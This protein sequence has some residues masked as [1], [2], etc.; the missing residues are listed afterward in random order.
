M[1]SADL[2]N[3][4][5]DGRDTRQSEEQV[6]D[7]AVMLANEGQSIQV[8][9][10]DSSTEQQAVPAVSNDSQG[11][12][13][14]GE[15]FTPALDNGGTS[16]DVEMD[17]AT[18]DTKGDAPPMNATVEQTA[19][20]EAG[21]AST[22][23][24]TK[25]D[26]SPVNATVGQTTELE[27]GS[28]TTIGDTKS[29]APLVDATVEETTKL[30]AGSS[31]T[32]GDAPPVYVT[33]E[34]TVK[35]EAGSSEQIGG[36]VPSSEL[37][38]EVVEL[39]SG[40]RAV[41]ALGAE[42]GS[43][44]ENP[45]D[46]ARNLE[47]SITP[48]GPESSLHG[49]SMTQEAAPI[50]TSS[51]ETSSA[52]DDQSQSFPV[53][54]GNSTSQETTPITASSGEANPAKGL[55][56]E[57]SHVH[58]GGQEAK[59]ITTTIS[60]EVNPS[61]EVKST[62]DVAEKTNSDSAMEVDEFSAPIVA[63]VDRRSPNLLG[64]LTRNESIII[65]Q[66]KDANE[67]KYSKAHVLHF[68][69]QYLDKYTPCSDT[70]KALREDVVRHKLLPQVVSWDGQTRAGNLDDVVWR[71]GKINRAQDVV[72]R[73]VHAVHED[74]QKMSSIS[75][76][77][78]MKLANKIIGVRTKIHDAERQL[79]RLEG[80]RMVPNARFEGIRIRAELETL[81]TEADTIRERLACLPPRAKDSI[82]EDA[83][84]INTVSILQKM[85]FVK[86]TQGHFG[87]V[88]CICVDP[89]GKFIV[90]GADDSLIKVW[91]AH[92][93]DLMT[94]LRGHSHN[95]CDLTMKYA[96]DGK[97][98]IL[99]STSDDLTIR[100]WQLP[101]GRALCVLKGHKKGVE[102][103]RFDKNT[104]VLFSASN[105]GSL[106]MWDTDTIFDATVIRKVAT[107]ELDRRP[108]VLPHVQVHKDGAK[109]VDVNTVA[110][111]PEGEVV[112]S[113]GGDGVIR[114]WCGQK[115]PS[116]EVLASCKHALIASAP[117]VDGRYYDGAGRLIQLLDKTGLSVVNTLVWSVTGHRLLATSM[118]DGSVK[119]WEWKQSRE[120]LAICASFV[121]NT[122]SFC[123]SLST[124][125][126]LPRKAKP[127]VPGQGQT[128]SGSSTSKTKK[129]K[130]T[131]G[132]DA[133]AWSC[134][135]RWIITAQTIVPSQS[136]IR[137]VHAYWDQQL[138]VWDTWANGELVHVLRKHRNQCLAVV[139][140]PTNPRLCMSAGWDGLVLLWD[141]IDGVLLCEN[142]SL[143]SNGI[144]F[145]L[146]LQFLPYAKT[147]ADL[148]CSDSMGRLN[149]LS[150]GAGK[151][152]RAAPPQQFF[153]ND[154]GQL[155]YDQNGNA[156]D[157]AS[158]LPPH[159]VP[160]TKLCD[161]QLVPYEFQLETHS[162][163]DR[164]RFVANLENVLR[165]K[166]SAALQEVKHILEAQDKEIEDRASGAVIQAARE[167]RAPTV[168]RD[169]L[170]AQATRPTAPATQARRTATNA[171]GTTTNTAP[172][173]VLRTY[174][175]LSSALDDEAD[176]NYDVNMDV[177]EKD[178]D[179]NI[180]FMPLDAAD[181]L[182]PVPG[183]NLAVADQ[184]VLSGQE[185]SSGRSVRRA[186]KR[187]Q[188]RM[189]HATDILMAP[190]SNLTTQAY[191]EEANDEGEVAVASPK[192][193]P[194]IPGLVTLLE[195]EWNALS[196]KFERKWVEQH[197]VRIPQFG[198]SFIYV[199]Q[200][201]QYHNQIEIKSRTSL[202]QGQAS[203]LASLYAPWKL[204][205]FSK[206]WSVLMC[207]VVD[208]KYVFPF[209]K[210]SLRSGEQV[211]V[212]PYHRQSNAIVLEI[213]VSVVMTPP[214]GALASV[215]RTNSWQ[216]HNPGNGDARVM[217][218]VQ[219]TSPLGPEIIIPVEQ[220]NAY[221]V[222]DF[223][224]GMT[225]TD[226]EGR[227]GTVSNC[228]A[229]DP[230][231]FPN[232]PFNAISV[233]IGAEEHLFSPWDLKPEGTQL[234]PFNMPIG[235]PMSCATSQAIAR[236]L[237]SFAAMNPSAA[238]FKEPVDVK[239]FFAYLGFVPLP[240]DF[241]TICDLLRKDYYRSVHQ[242]MIDIIRMN[243]N[244]MAF[245]PVGSAI[246]KTA[247]V[248]LRQANIQ[249]VNAI[250]GTEIPMQYNRQK[251]ELNKPAT[252]R[253]KGAPRFRKTP[254]VNVT[255]SQLKKAPRPVS[256][257][258]S[259]SSAKSAKA[260]RI[261]HPKAPVMKMPSG[262]ARKPPVASNVPQNMATQSSTQASTMAR[263]AEMRKA[264]ASSS[265]SA[266]PSNQS[267]TYGAAAAGLQGQAAAPSSLTNLAAQYYGAGATP[268]QSP[269]LG[270]GT[271]PFLSPFPSP[272][273]ESKLQIGSGLPS[274][275][276]KTGATP[277]SKEAT[278]APTRYG[279][280]NGVDMFN[281]QSAPPQ[282][283]RYI[284]G[285]NQQLYGSSGGTGGDLFFPYQ[286]Q[287]SVLNNST[288]GDMYSYWNPNQPAG[289]QQQQMYYQQYQM[290]GNSAT[291][292]AS[293]QQTG[294]S[295]TSSSG[296]GSKPS[297]EQT[298]TNT[299][300][301]SSTNTDV[302]KLKRKP[303]GN[304][305]ESHSKRSKS[306]TE[307]PQIS[308][309]GQFQAL[310]QPQV[311][312]D[313]SVNA[314][315]AINSLGQAEIL[316]QFATKQEAVLHFYQQQQQQHYSSFPQ[317]FMGQQQ[318]N[319]QWE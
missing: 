200:A 67:G 11:D 234:T 81:Y 44:V 76:E 56:S 287:T 4:I 238:A 267:F 285:Q 3:G 22:T 281:P 210:R 314:W 211:L 5:S 28:A 249:I 253:K 138:R 95:V 248:V 141:I 242:V 18:G 147:G 205:G 32:K 134:D 159:L 219:L 50:T 102:A 2:H 207:N 157:N 89:E 15:G 82:D 283:Q 48:S 305:T 230:A 294:T 135:D 302:S 137:N 191:K 155:I 116:K 12:K 299:S 180:G 221:V 256:S 209:Q 170:E 97:T 198:D 131:P 77:E 90:T 227:T 151:D 226:K 7:S 266:Y 310:Q 300:V 201:H 16:N 85:H 61:T 161:T 190:N 307:Q 313:K 186:A 63:S 185:A 38:K 52:K 93:G 94:T 54:G 60:G 257:S 216:R 166:E 45:I 127:Q 275:A 295:T 140:H 37:D 317:Q 31:E 176:E 261:H 291:T 88:Y 133:V 228:R 122:P 223:K 270:A 29:D 53:H 114:I 130:K 188:G 71:F 35:L 278:S 202:Y 84:K 108:T 297:M 236:A 199:T 26:A 66:I 9:Q 268:S 303:S 252:S 167:V 14:A 68:I 153:M 241:R 136:N 168:Y 126:K 34:E 240:T 272:S 113:G 33:V 132:L 55:E 220:F 203:Y 69:C 139:A 96:K 74:V 101:S 213:T 73:L 171:A 163:V 263:A 145:V 177:E 194:P 286:Q 119:V 179:T 247:N 36:V 148:V 311:Y 129:T 276:S 250:P 117:L 17:V 218:T 72:D 279:T 110:V 233:R 184:E 304:K 319:Q 225:V 204:Q 258:S 232:S 65:Q 164:A 306:Q 23:G 109:F 235:Q 41:P 150:T 260:P 212:T 111:H 112:A 128:I 264:Q 183:S 43:V 83:R 231:Q 290:Q 98:T 292:A 222:Q 118:Q 239:I 215:P 121:F 271:A 206:A 51:G 259:S 40:G 59:I 217:F 293:K 298:T 1:E 243:A 312:F 193:P 169:D 143:H 195:K 100:L 91:S 173:P 189:R 70:V 158:Q 115:K 296:V 246:R 149:F 123:F 49:S 144:A 251:N 86:K 316:G 174:S 154:K 105:D 192:T 47:S 46:S 175:S 30:E 10:A 87:F 103:I 282:Q 273:K 308:A 187:A 6:K 229:F 156:L 19:E 62:V 8:G 99:A 39:P 21:S 181:E 208:M 152:Y 315:V 244:C 178:D 27:A 92:T 277:A 262:G 107:T 301:G 172:A 309:G 79:K 80:P 104:G 255:S 197:G 254:V 224:P 58:E 165:L 196:A 57:S 125:T 142:I 25:G 42:M 245:N 288:F 237:E 120:D 214:L 124:Q 269:K 20:L 24:D 75:P 289:Q 162:F 265:T 318:Q 64:N 106:C 274:P 280:A 78:K 160:K 182:R 284:A 146:D 13:V